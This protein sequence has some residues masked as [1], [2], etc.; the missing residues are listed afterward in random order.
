MGNDIRRIT[1][2]GSGNVA[3]ALALNIAG[4][5]GVELVEVVARNA[6]RG[7]AIAM[8][9][10]CDFVEMGDEVAQADLYIIAVSDRAVAEVA[11][12]MELSEEAI[13]VHTAGSVELST[14]G[15]GR[16]GV[17]YPFQ[18]F[19]AG[20]AIDLSDVPIFIEGSD[21]ATTAALEAFAE[22]LSSK[23]Y[24]ADSHRRREI[25]LSGVWACNFVNAL[26][27]VAADVLHEREGLSFEV[28]QPLI[29]ETAHKA[30]EAVHPAA[31]QTGP[32]RRGDNEVMARHEAMLTDKP[33]LQE[34][35]RLISE[36]IY[37]KR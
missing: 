17:F 21:E 15:R 4:A 7:E 28:L 10:G 25:H 2:I 11:E 12:A 5:W 16:R 37:K 35:Y 23:V 1:V 13:V 31:V 34:I 36:E 26:Y 30:A 19:T 32:A 24:R 27:G 6:E 18:T 9:A 3:E 33:E 8:A 20:R 14:L 29:L 22:Q